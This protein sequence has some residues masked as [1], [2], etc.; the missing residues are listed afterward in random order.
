MFDFHL[1]TCVSFDSDADPK[2]MIAAAARAGL[3]EI[4]FTDHSDDD[5]LGERQAAFKLEDYLRVLTPYM[6]PPQPVKVRFGA[7]IGAS[8]WAPEKYDAAA[9]QFDYDFIICSAHFVGDE[10]PY[11]PE[12][13][14]KRGRREAFDEYFLEVIRDIECHDVFNVFGH[15]TYASKCCIYD[16]PV[17][18]YAEFADYYDKI[19]K[20]LIERGKGIEV[21]TSGYR[22]TG[23]PLPHFEIIKRYLE[24]GG[25]IITIGSDAHD[26][27]R[28]GDRIAET[29]DRIKALGVRRIC[30]FEKMK[31]VFHV[32]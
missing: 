26:P 6:D 16:D 17:A 28:V 25:E 5:P 24:L 2:D 19:L 7:E 29:I 4:C 18:H 3:R 8:P 23:E 21:N 20:M 32:I 12:Y 9:A 30:T 13:F 10:D 31:P 15:L 11:Y 14:E 27:S 1:H 22:N